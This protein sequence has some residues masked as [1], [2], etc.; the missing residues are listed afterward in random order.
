MTGSWICLQMLGSGILKTTF[1]NHMSTHTRQINVLPQELR[2][3][4]VPIEVLYP[5]AE[6]WPIRFTK[7]TRELNEF[8]HAAF[9]VVFLGPT[10][11][12]KSTLINHIFNRTA[13]GT[14]ASA[15]SCT[16]EVN[17]YRGDCDWMDDY[18]RGNVSKKMIN[19]ID[20][21]GN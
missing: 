7:M 12:G 4:S 13:C 14:S 10:G 16:R 11:S 5:E 3:K 19:V 15:Q 1:F 9:N 21:I 6:K 17:F 18:S 2:P 8:D 20:T